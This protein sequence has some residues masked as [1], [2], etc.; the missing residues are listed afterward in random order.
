MAFDSAADLAFIFNDV[1]AQPATI[2]NG[3]TTV[4]T[5]PVIFDNS[6]DTVSV[7]DQ[8]VTAGS[9]KVRVRTTDLAGIVAGQHTMVIDSVTYRITK[10]KADGNGV[11][12]LWLKK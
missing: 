10:P 7:F 3:G 9:Q 8:E 2:K 1:M 12:T 6:L 4:R 11:S 5:V